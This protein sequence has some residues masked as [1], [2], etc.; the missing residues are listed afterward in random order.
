ME[1]DKYFKTSFTTSAHH[2]HAVWSYNLR[3][4]PLEYSRLPVLLNDSFTKTLPFREMT[5]QF[6]FRQ[7]K[8]TKE[9]SKNSW[10][11]CHWLHSKHNTKSKRLK[12]R[13]PRYPLRCTAANHGNCFL[14]KQPRS[15]LFEICRE[16]LRFGCKSRKTTSWPQA[17]GA[18]L[19][20]KIM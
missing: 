15:S 4:P 11:H 12:P 19:S 7:H 17:H 20:G 8:T 9:R 10:N 6:H 18:A 2:W 13:W 3:F 5:R 16:M 1:P 14:C